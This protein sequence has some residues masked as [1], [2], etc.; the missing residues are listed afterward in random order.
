[1]SYY[2]PY[3]NWVGVHP[4]YTLTNQMTRVL[5]IAYMQ[6]EKWPH[7]WGNVGKYSLHGASG[8]AVALARGYKVGPKVTSYISYPFSHNYGHGKLS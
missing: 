6:G 4:L 3:N 8:L 1:M 7:A 5:F 2:N